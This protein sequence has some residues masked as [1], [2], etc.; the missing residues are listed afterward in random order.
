MPDFTG[1]INASIPLQAGQGVTQPINPLSTYSQYQQLASGRNQIQQQQNELSMFPGQQALQQQAVQGGSLAL[2][3]KTNQAAYA[4]L[5]PYLSDPNMTHDKLTTA[6]AGIEASG[7]PTGGI[8]ADFQKSLPG[9]DGPG[10]NQSLR[11]L[12]GSRMLTDPGAQLAANVGTPGTMANGQQ[13]QP[14]IVGGVLSGQPGG[15][16]PSG[17]PTQVYPTRSELL[18]QQPGVDPAT[19]QPT[20]TPL[21]TRAA[22]QG[23]SGLTGPAGAPTV[24]SPF[25]NGGRFA[26][27]MPAALLRNPPGGAPAAAPGGAVPVG[28]SPAQIAAQ[29]ATG[30][31]SAQAFQ[32]ISAQGV[33]ARSQNALLGNM[34]GDAAQFTTGQTGVNNFK[35][36]LQRQAPALAQVF[37]LDPAKVAANESFD[38][39]AAQIADAQGAGSDARLAVNQHANP[40]SAIS[41]AGVDQI[42]RQLQGNGD[43]QQARAQ[44]AASF[45]DQTNRAAFEAQVGSNLDP[46]AFQFARMTPQQK[47]TYAKSLSPQDRSALQKSYNFAATNGLI[48][49][50]SGQ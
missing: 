40:S 34:L 5:S 29:T 11:S 43:Y 50:A 35:T 7:I 27:T 2:A 23:Q 26:P 1:G 42:V 30:G 10:F 46:R 32:D 12:V 25:A 13:I 18:T 41:P 19:G 39:L 6:L 17:A 45:P 15:F 22:A 8:I 33:Q 14:G 31:Q 4:M 21:A 44:M 3:Q 37:G 47:V 9:G 38:K 24:P 28:Q 16:T 48:G 36:T 20:A 49:G